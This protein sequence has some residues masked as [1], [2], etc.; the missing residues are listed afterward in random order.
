M[1]GVVQQVLRRPFKDTQPSIDL[2]QDV[3]KNESKMTQDILSRNAGDDCPQ[4]VPAGPNCWSLG[5]GSE[6]SS[7]C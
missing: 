2:R 5:I 1:A 7:F 6:L 4:L 3:F